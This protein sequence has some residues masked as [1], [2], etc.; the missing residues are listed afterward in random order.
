MRRS[1]AYVSAPIPSP[2]AKRMG[3]FAAISPLRC[4]H[5]G[6]QLN[7]VTLSPF[8]GAYPERLPRAHAPFVRYQL[9][10]TVCCTVVNRGIA[11][12]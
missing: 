5:R 2:S 9:A 10:T 7:T 6:G 12:P 11:R 8:V 4:I 1:A 3:T